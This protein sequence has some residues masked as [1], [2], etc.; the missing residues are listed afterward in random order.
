METIFNPE[1]MLGRYLIERRDLLLASS[2]EERIELARRIREHA[3][4]LN[5]R[6]VL[7]ATSCQLLAVADWIERL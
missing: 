1:T 5:I 6:Y 4:T 2:V 3:N 7:C